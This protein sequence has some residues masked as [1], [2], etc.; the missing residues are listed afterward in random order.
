MNII[1]QIEQDPSNPNIYWIDISVC[2]KLSEE[3]IAKFQDKVNWNCISIYQKLSEEFITKFQDKVDWNCISKHQKLSE[4]FMT[5][6]QDKVYWYYISQYQKLSEEFMTKFQ[7][8]VYWN[9]ISTYQK[10]SEE[11][12]TKFQDKVNWKYISM[13]QKL[14]EEFITKF[15]D[16]VSWYYISIYQKLSEEFIKTNN[17]TIPK[18]SWLYKSIEWKK[19]YLKSHTKYEVLDDKIIAYKSTRLDGYSVFNYQYKYEVGNDYICHADFNPKN[20]NSFGL[21]AWTREGALG[22]NN[23]GELYEVEINIADIAAIV[24]NNSKIRASKIKIVK[25]L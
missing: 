23:R 10:L 21:S 11:F 19:E 24:Y 16:K 15:Q 8:K 6:F 22:Y 4:E 7:D 5:K 14:S 3:F 17:L 12:I 9:C 13:Y 20:E 2:Q 18:D 25:K 1:E